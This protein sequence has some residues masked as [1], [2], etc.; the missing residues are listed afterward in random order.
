MDLAAGLPPNDRE[1]FWCS[2]V[3]RPGPDD[4]RS[5]T[6]ERQVRLTITGAYVL[7]VDPRTTCSTLL[8]EHSVTGSKKGC[9]QGECAAAPSLSSTAHHSCPRIAVMRDG[10]E[11]PHRG[12][13][14]GG[15]LHPMQ[16]RSIRHVGCNCATARPADLFRRLCWRN[17]GGMAQHATRIRTRRPD[18][19]ES[20]NG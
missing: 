2:H 8:R 19:A 5:R 1:R 13:G 17:P 3:N 18:D 14:T 12:P 7:D 6:A 11:S 4:G 15:R 20:P 16:A 9:D 10:D